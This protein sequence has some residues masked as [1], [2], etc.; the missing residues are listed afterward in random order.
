MSAGSW[1]PG[2]CFGDS[3][4]RR[5]AYSRR[6]GPDLQPAAGRF[7]LLDL[8]HFGY[9]G[10]TV[11]AGYELMVCALMAWYM[12]GAIILNELFGR[13]LLPAGKPWIA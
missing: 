2:R 9:P 1:W 11:I 3:V 6:H 8:A 10:L 5:D 7:I 13:E 4:N 12:I